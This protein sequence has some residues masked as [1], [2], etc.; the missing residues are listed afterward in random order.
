LDIEGVDYDL[1]GR[2]E[3]FIIIIAFRW[4]TSSSRCQTTS[5]KTGKKSA[6]MA[7]KF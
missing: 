3:A 2:F 7:S 5:R 6:G 1:L 4:G